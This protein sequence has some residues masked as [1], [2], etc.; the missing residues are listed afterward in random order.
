VKNVFLALI[1]IFAYGVSAQANTVKYRI[2]ITGDVEL[3]RFSDVY[4]LPEGNQVGAIEI[5]DF[6]EYSGTAFFGL[7]SGSGSAI[8]TA[9]PI[10]GF[11]SVVIEDCVGMLRTLCW[12]EQQADLTRGLFQ[13]SDGFS[14][15]SR[16]NPFELFYSDD[17]F[18]R[19]SYL[20][21]EY[22]AEF[23][24]TVRSQLDSYS[25]QVIPL[26]ASWTFLIASLLGGVLFFRR[27]RLQAH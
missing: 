10:S 14:F 20:G 21:Y 6:S 27:R 19:F 22:R 24:I 11:Q 18:Y 3:I 4:K 25:I 13:A 7:L 9:Q 8:V 12:S 23:G 17:F 5:S 1:I 2:H 15:I 26:P 16:L